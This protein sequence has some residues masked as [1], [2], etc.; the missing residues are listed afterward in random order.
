MNWNQVPLPEPLRLPLL[1]QPWHHTAFVQRRYPPEALRPLV[2]EAL[3]ID[4]LDGS[5]W[6]GLVMFECQRTRVPGLPPV[7]VPPRFTEVNL[8]TYVTAPGDRPAL[9]FFALEASN[10][11]VVAGGRLLAGVP[12][13]PAVTSL[14]VEDGELRYRSERLWGGTKVD[15][16]VV[17]GAAFDEG[18]L[19][20]LD[21]FLTARWGAYS[22]VLG[23]LRYTP[24]DHP[25]WPLH[26]AELA[27]LE[28]DLTAAC[29][30]PDPEGQPLLHHASPIEATLGAS[31]SVGPQPSG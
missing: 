18:E 11:A 6:V 4:E 7:L 23:R 15:A 27:S 5:A 29:R 10:P 14:V 3:E 21:H 2:P 12:Y 31:R 8:R 24:V 25:L 26:H 13:N 28:Q 16:R 30:L 1:R 22:L 19:G 17:P 9:W 20:P